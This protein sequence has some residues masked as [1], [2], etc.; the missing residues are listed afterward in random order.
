MTTLTDYCIL[1]E[2]ST[3]INAWNQIRSNPTEVKQLFSNGAYFEI[4][5]DDYNKWK[6]NNPTDLHAYLGVKDNRIVL[7]S[8]DSKTD[9]EEV[10]SHM[11]AFNKLIKVAPYL[12]SNLAN[13][14]FDNVT[15]VGE[16]TPNLNPQEALE[17][18]TRWLLYRDTWIWKNKDEMTQVL[19][20]PFS[21]L[22]T[23]FA[24]TVDSVLALLA[25]KPVDG[26]N[27]TDFQL[28]FILWG[29]SND[30]GIEAWLPEDIVRPCPPFSN[31]SQY[32]L[33]IYSTSGA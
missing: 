9:Q 6:G 29:Y 7:Y 28:E 30:S 23:I 22:D 13:P 3:A 8:I 11:V 18:T 26:G 32:Q 10:N 15:I 20:I 1:E 16:G 24:Q 27:S 14:S 17:R 5:R 21:D 4:Q 2:A 12:P 33:L 25:L 31:L 19:S